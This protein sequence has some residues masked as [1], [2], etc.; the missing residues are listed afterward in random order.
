MRRSTAPPLLPA[1]QRS[2]AAHVGHM[3]AVCPPALF[4]AAACACVCFACR[5]SVVAASMIPRPCDGWTEPP[6][7]SCGRPRASMWPVPGHSRFAAQSRTCTH[8]VCA[9]VCFPAAPDFSARLCVC[10]CLPVRLSVRRCWRAR[11]RARCLHQVTDAGVH[12]AYTHQGW[13]R[14]CPLPA[15]IA[16]PHAACRGM[17]LCW[18]QQGVVCAARTGC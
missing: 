3:H 7:P 11:E 4:H 9:C 14:G 8:C 6:R 2:D 10:V 13:G 15:V 16:C 5:S 12:P 1:Q 18:Q 17:Y